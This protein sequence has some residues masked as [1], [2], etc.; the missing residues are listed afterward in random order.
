MSG[1]L[2][3]SEE[4]WQV[5]ACPAP[6]HGALRAD[7]ERFMLVCTV[8]AREFPVRNGIPML[9]LD[10]ALIPDVGNSGN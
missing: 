4:L 2:G 3:L 8:C 5:I 1:A 7:E 9:L 10:E 6:D